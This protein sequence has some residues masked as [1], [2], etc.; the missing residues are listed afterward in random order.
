MSQPQVYYVGQH[1]SMGSYRF[2]AVA[3][4]SPSHV[5]LLSTL[6]AAA[7]QASLSITNSQSLLKLM[8]IE[9][10]KPPSHLILCGIYVTICK[11][12]SK[13]EFAE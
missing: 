7:L 2:L 13:E 5:R 10:G 6:W 11:I 12:D 9:S 3:I 8:S 1:G 4:W